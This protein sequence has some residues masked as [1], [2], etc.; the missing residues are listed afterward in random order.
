MN[1]ENFVV[2]LNAPGGNGFTLKTS[3]RFP[4][5]QVVRDDA[6][7][8]C[9]FRNPTAFEFDFGAPNDKCRLAAGAG[10]CACGV[11]SAYRVNCVSLRHLLIVHDDDLDRVR[12]TC[13]CGP[14]AQRAHRTRACAAWTSKSSQSRNSLCLMWTKCPASLVISRHRCILA[15]S[16]RCLPET[17][18]FNSYV[19]DARVLCGEN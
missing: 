3:P 4:V 7:T 16:P 5:G 6:S 2:G 1:S 10:F 9:D 18:D 11:P 13:A 14:S 17:V 8:V 12:T 19:P 15:A